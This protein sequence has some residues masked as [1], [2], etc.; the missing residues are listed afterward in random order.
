MLKF[1]DGFCHRTMQN[2]LGDLEKF[3]AL[4]E[5]NAIGLNDIV[6]SMKAKERDSVEAEGNRTHTMKRELTR[7]VN[8]KVEEDI[9]LC[10][11]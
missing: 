9:T 5:R 4:D 7:S 8:Y 11:A 1:G 10:N 6:I 3:M 2:E